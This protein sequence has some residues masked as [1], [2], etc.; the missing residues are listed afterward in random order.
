MM[1]LLTDHLLPAR[2]PDG[3]II[4]CDLPGLLASYVD[5][6]IVDLP[7]LRRHQEASWHCFLVQLAALALHRAG[8]ADIPDSADVWRSLLRRLTAD[9]PDDEPWRLVVDDVERPA[10]MQPP[11]LM[12]A[13]DPHK[14]PV[15]TADD[16]D[17]LV[18]SKNH[19]L[20]Q[21]IGGDASAEVWIVALVML[22]TCSGFLGSGNYGIARMN[23]G[24]ATRPFVALQP[25]GG[26]GA[27]WQRDVSVL[28]KRRD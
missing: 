15:D 2:T 10:F 7:F 23:G 18:T 9:W 12:G 11:V 1:N 27:H 22:Q 8:E 19:G 6:G 26:P 28:L 14:A 3:A 21:G 16:P 4:S 17:V 25:Q 5:D 20:K 24:F 13:G